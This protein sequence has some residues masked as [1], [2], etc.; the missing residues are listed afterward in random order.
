MYSLVDRPRIVILPWCVLAFAFVVFCV[1]RTL[2]ALCLGVVLIARNVTFDVASFTPVIPVDS[3]YDVYCMR[4]YV[5][6]F[7]FLEYYFARLIREC[8]QLTPDRVLYRRFLS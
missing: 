5:L 6:R 2:Q 4:P 8:G 1:Y 7:T 3:A